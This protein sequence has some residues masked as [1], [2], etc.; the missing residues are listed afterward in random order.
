M[1]DPE[2][3]AQS[4]TTAEELSG[5]AGAAPVHESQNGS[6]AGAD[7]AEPGDIDA[8]NAERE[9]FLGN[10]DQ[11][12]NGGDGEQAEG[13]QA[14]AGEAAADGEQGGEAQGKQPETKPDEKQEE[15]EGKEA[16]QDNSDGDA[17][18]PQYR[19]RPQSETE[20]LAFDIYKRGQRSG[21]NIPL[22]DAVAQAKQILGQGDSQTEA[23][24]DADQPK[25]VS[26]AQARL[27]ELRAALRKAQYEDLDFEQAKA[28][29]EQIE[30]LRDRIGDLKIAE[31][32]QREHARAEWDGALEAAKARAVEL[33]PE[34]TNAESALVK[35]MNAIDAEL[36]ASDNP[37]VSQPDY[38]VKLSQLAANE[39]G[40]APKAG[41]RKGATTQAAASSAP[42]KKTV[43]SVQPAS[44]SA[45]T[46]PNNKPE[47]FDVELG[48][49]NDEEAYEKL[50]EKLG[51]V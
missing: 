20:A 38:P 3:N 39:L 11:D 5:K 7:G 37:L 15:E 50:V 2:A 25:T 8:Y 48:Q 13:A 19:L 1:S 32:K 6:P 49:V 41:T 43:S 28:L 45:R 51:K 26:E 30:T 17:K 24:G 42:A 47:Q 31:G 16:S 10:P 34:V 9:Q 29:D 21:K 33:Y 35:R 27:T 14:S 46:T 44:G 36:R 22:E 12:N 23:G 18:P 40:V 4:S